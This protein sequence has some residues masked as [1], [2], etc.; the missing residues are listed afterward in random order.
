MLEEGEGRRG[1]KPALSWELWTEG[2]RWHGQLIPLLKTDLPT[3]SQPQLY[4]EECL[5]EYKAKTREITWMQHLFGDFRLL[6]HKESIS[7]LVRPAED[8]WRV[9]TTAFTNQSTLL[10]HFFL[11]FNISNFNVYAYFSDLRQIKNKIK[12]IYNHLL[13][14]GIHF[15]SNP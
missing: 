1:E 9:K 8:T 13:A 14:F 7:T 5:D 11:S 15:P 12:I 3:H 6:W 2:L 10:T 4:S